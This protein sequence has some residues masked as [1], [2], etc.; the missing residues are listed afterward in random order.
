MAV[1]NRLTPMWPTAGHRRILLAGVVL[2]LLL[3]SIG[4]D[5]LVGQTVSLGD[6]V[7]AGFCHRLLFFTAW[8]EDA[9]ADP[10]HT[11]TI[12]I[13]GPDPFGPVLDQVEGELVDQ[14]RLVIIRFD[15]ETDPELLKRCQLLFISQGYSGDVDAVLAGLRDNPV[16]TVSDTA[17]FADRGGMVGFVT[18][19][20][21]IRFE[22]NRR[23]LD[24]ARLELHSQV[25][26]MATKVIGG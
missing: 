15:S 11:I 9:F 5:S 17:G 20:D 24:R 13:L 25:L 1:L 23:A 16:L 3:M 4:P 7:K 19:D 14:R 8:P 10:P 26:Q 12:G 6:Q 2:A 21:R 18:A 22:I